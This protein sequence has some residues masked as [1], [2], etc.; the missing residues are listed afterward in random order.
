VSAFAI[1]HGRRSLIL[2]IT[3][4]ALH[5]C[6][7]PVHTPLVRFI[8]TIISSTTLLVDSRTHSSSASSHRDEYVLCAALMEPNNARNTFP[9]RFR[10]TVLY[11]NIIICIYVYV[12]SAFCFS[13]FFK[14][15]IFRFVYFYIILYFII[16]PYVYNIIAYY[17]RY[18]TTT[19]T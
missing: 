6:Y 9:T 13:L 4:A 5:Y 2:I 18:K 19:Y 7:N 1:T 14:L 8:I 17:E 3:A 16:D 15:T 10:P 11:N 12:Q